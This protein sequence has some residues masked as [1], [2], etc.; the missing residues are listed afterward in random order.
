MILFKSI[1]AHLSRTADSSVL[2]RFAFLIKEKNMI[3]LK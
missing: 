2:K 1:L 3:Y